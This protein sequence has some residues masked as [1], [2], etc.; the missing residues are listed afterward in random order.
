MLRRHSAL[1]L[2]AWALLAWPAAATAPA[3]RS[4]SPSFSVTVDGSQRTTITAVR[5]SVDDLG[6]TVTRRDEQRQALTFFTREPGRAVVPAS[7]TTVSRVRV[8]VGVSG[9]STRR[10]TISGQA[11]ECDLAPDVVVGDCEAAAVAGTVI[12][13]LSGAGTVAVRGSLAPSRPSARCAPSAGRARPF[14]VSS[15]GH[16]PAALLTDR[17]AARIVL[18]GDARFSDTLASGARRVTTVRWIV[19]LRRRS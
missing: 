3:A 7:G 9:A 12:V 15:E 19:T 10:R 8:A 1:V 4:V 16:F 5:R 6:C 11:P 14:L 13:R 18:R 17:R 2:L